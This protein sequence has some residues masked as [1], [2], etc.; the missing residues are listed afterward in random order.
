MPA[1]TPGNEISKRPS[2][3]MDLEQ[4]QAGVIGNE[5][6]TVLVSLVLLALLS[7]CDP[8]SYPNDSTPVADKR[9][10]HGTTTTTSTTVP[11]ATST[12]VPATTTS[13]TVPATTTTSTTVPAGGGTT[14]S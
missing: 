13:T 3:S 12:T 5:R 1:R 10:Q 9:P 8:T 2:E 14:C 4:Q 6:L 7:A 11:A